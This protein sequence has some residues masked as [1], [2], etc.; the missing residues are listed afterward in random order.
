[1]KLQLRFPLLL[2]F[3]CV[4]LSF[5]AFSQVN[6][7]A[8]DATKNLYCQLKKIAE[9]RHLMYGQHHAYLLGH[10]RKLDGTFSDTKYICGDNPAVVGYDLV[11]FGQWDR[12]NQDKGFVRQMKTHHARGGINT[13]S[14]H[15]ENPA[16]QGH[17]TEGNPVTKILE[18]NNA[19]R[20]YYEQRLEDAAVFF[21]SLR[22]DNGELIP[23]IFR[24]LHEQLHSAFW[25]GAKH[26]TPEE[27]AALWVLTY[28]IMTHTHGVNNLLWAFSPNQT[29]TREIYLSR[30]P[31]FEYMDIIGLDGYRNGAFPEDLHTWCQVIVSIA[32]EQG[33]VAAITEMGDRGGFDQNT[34]SDWYSQQLINNLKDDPSVNKLAYWMTWGSVEWSAYP[35]GDPKGGGQNQYADFIKFYE[36]D[37][38]LFEQDLPD[39]YADCQEDDSA[40]YLEIVSP[41]DGTTY[42]ESPIKISVDVISFDTNG[43]IT[44]VDLYI[45]G[46][47]EATRTSANAGTDRYVWYD[48]GGLRNLPP[49]TYEIKVVATDDDGAQSEAISNITI[50]TVT[51]HGTPQADVFHENLHVYPNPVKEELRLSQEGA[52]WRVY[53][54]FQQELLTGTGKTINTSALPSGIYFL[55]LNGGKPLKFIK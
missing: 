6:S 35:P 21:K 47:L 54:C 31:G 9:S 12:D 8:T 38:T 55:R 32:E 10:Y 18:G 20:A 30:F 53:D 17:G 50:G 11:K 43:A 45:D 28:D 15:M 4:A 42:W 23:I 41:I 36:D 40:P 51:G 44:Q 14:W 34:P 5:S 49:G 7:N 1:M 2:A 37:W 39:M 26:C 16:T 33:K 52:A 46:Q 13:V 24:P 48:R 29:G 19:T 22:D 3:W 25:W 27:Y